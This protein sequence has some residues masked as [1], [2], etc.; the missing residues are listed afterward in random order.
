MELKKLL[1]IHLTLYGDETEKTIVNS[2]ETFKNI[3]GNITF[4]SDELL[5]IKTIDSTMPKKIFREWKK[6]YVLL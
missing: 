6:Y 3:V 2:F 4:F 5:E 1:L